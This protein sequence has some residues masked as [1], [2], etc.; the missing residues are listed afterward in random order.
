MMH[1]TLDRVQVNHLSTALLTVLL[2]P[3]LVGTA[4]K[5]TSY[6]SISI[7]ASEA[8]YVDVSFM[9]QSHITSAYHRCHM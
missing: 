8:H 9:W 7:V 1:R 3:T 4:D 2:L 5:H 6:P